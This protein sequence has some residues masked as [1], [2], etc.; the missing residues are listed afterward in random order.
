[1]GVGW[2][3]RQTISAGE[4]LRSENGDVFAD[5]F[6]DAGVDVVE[7]SLVSPAARKQ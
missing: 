7:V 5:E 6:V 2:G 1:M 4:L 3:V